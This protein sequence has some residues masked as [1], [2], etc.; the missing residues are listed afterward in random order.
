MKLSVR[1]PPQNQ[2]IQL[3]LQWSNGTANWVENSCYICQVLNGSCQ[4]G[5][6][7]Q[8]QRTSAHQYAQH[9]FLPMQVRTVDQ[10]CIYSCNNQALR[11]DEVSQASRLGFELLWL[12][13]P[14]RCLM[15]PHSIELNIKW[16]K[17]VCHRKENKRTILCIEGEKVWQANDIDDTYLLPSK[18]QP[19]LSAGNSERRF[20][21][22][23]LQLIPFKFPGFPFLVKVAS[24]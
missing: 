22:T 8:E 11:T 18:N 1:S 6:N 17:G 9:L 4:V 20:N 13:I 3:M 16:R 10:W 12:K 5:D 2:N 7:L 14:R 19:L 24:G 23:G 15:Q 21:D